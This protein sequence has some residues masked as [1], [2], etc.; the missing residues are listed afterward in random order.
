M[1][2][3]RVWR[4]CPAA[5][6]S[7]LFGGQGGLYFSA[8]WHNQGRLITY[9]A[10]SRSLAALEI[11]ANTLDRDALACRP[12]VCAWADIPASL[13]E[14]PQRLPDDWRSHPPPSSTRAFGDAWLAAASAPA[15]RVPSAVIG[16]EFNYLLNPRHPAFAQIRLGPPEPFSFDPRLRPT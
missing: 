11:L 6:S 9:T 13:L 5:Y 3:L 1:S 8:R 12:W 14:I 10:E 4:I 2:V 15:L 7:D 16:G